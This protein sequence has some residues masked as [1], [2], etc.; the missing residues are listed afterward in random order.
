MRTALI[1]IAGAALSV[2]APTFAQLDSQTHNQAIAFADSL[3]D[4]FAGVAE[5][6]TPSVVSIQSISTVERAQQIPDAFMDENLRR[7]FGDRFEMPVPEQGEQRRQGQGTGFIYS[8][9]GYI[10]TNNH[11]VADADEVTVRLHDDRIFD[12]TV[13]GADPQTDIAVLKI[14]AS[15]LTPVD[16]SDSDDLRVGQ[17]VVAVGSPFGLD[18]SITAGI[19]SATG[20]TSFGLADYEDFIQ[21][22]AAINPGNSGGPLVDL[23]GNVVGMNTAIFTRSGGYN[24]IGFAIPADLVQHIASDLMV[25]GSVDRGWLGV[26]IQNLNEGLARSFG[27]EGTNG[28]LISSVVDDGPAAKAGLRDGDIVTAIDGKAVTDMSDLRFRVA[29]TDPGVELA[30]DITREGRTLTKRVTIGELE[31]EPSPRAA[32]STPESDLGMSLDTL[33]PEIAERLNTDATGVLVSSVEQFTPAWNAGLRRGDIIVKVSGQHVET[34]RDYRREI[35][36]HD[37][38]EGVRLTV[39]SQGAQRFVWLQND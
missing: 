6:I 17:W 24:G 33:T 9:D 18:A 20:R 26:Y 30:F 35:A 23:H 5:R 38:S 11:V 14:D 37:L 2:S 1:T 39:Q 36:R 3:S 12:A 29:H 13:V 16:L 10:L 34:L 21:T 27:F 32:A 28:V 4:A 19:V 7:F 25:D 22:D 31:A 8:H 15:G